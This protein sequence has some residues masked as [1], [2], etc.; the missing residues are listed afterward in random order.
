MR[1]RRKEKN[2]KCLIE[3]NRTKKDKKILKIL[4]FIKYL[5][6]KNNEITKLE[7]QLMN[8]K[9]FRSTQQ[10]VRVVIFY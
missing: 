1:C 10:S 4:F 7:N 8:N 2:G 9:K 5:Y 6:L 3:I